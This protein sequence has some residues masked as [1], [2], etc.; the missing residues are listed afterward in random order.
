MKSSDK[1]V[2]PN[3]GFN[4]DGIN[5]REYFIIHAP[6]KEIDKLIPK[7]VGGISE[8][9]GIDSSK[10]RSA[11]ISQRMQAIAKARGIWA[12]AMLRECGYGE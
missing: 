4:Q 2:Y 1:S 11:S 5:L 7:T 12:D 9:L 3:G 6:A 8:F 10:Y